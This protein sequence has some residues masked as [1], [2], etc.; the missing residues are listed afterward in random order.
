MAQYETPYT[1]SPEEIPAGPRKWPL[2]AVMLIDLVIILALILLLTL[3]MSAVIIGVR[4]VQQG[5][6]LGQKLRGYAGLSYFLARDGL[7]TPVELVVRGAERE[8]GRV[9]H[10]DEWGWRA[11]E[12]S[13]AALAGTTQ[14]VDTINVL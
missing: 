12:F 7:G 3:V 4:A 8:L 11:F 6:P 1:S 2:A 9:V 5:V 10:Q 14:E 13:T